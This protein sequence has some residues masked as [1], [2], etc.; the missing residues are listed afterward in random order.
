MRCCHA[1][2]MLGSL[3]PP[4]DMQVAGSDP[5]GWDPALTIAPRHPPGHPRRS[6]PP[7]GTHE[8]A[9]RDNCFHCDRSSVSRC[10]SNG[11][12]PELPHPLTFWVYITT[13]FI[14]HSFQYGGGV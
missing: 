14:N 11:L 3:P 7:Q 4:P 2:L 5:T 1:F 8:T 9:R 10:T 13:M 12:D 6:K